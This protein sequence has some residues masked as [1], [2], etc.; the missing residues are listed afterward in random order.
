[1]AEHGTPPEHLPS[2][3]LREV[4]Q[5]G[6]EQD[7]LPAPRKQLRAGTAG[8]QQF[9]APGS[10]SISGNPPQLG[11]PPYTNPTYLPHSQQGLLPPL[12]LSLVFVLQLPPKN[13]TKISISLQTAS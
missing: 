8:I 13:S 11:F 4:T 5:P 3:K 2:P 9:P 1:M 10:S 12:I 7:P 6:G